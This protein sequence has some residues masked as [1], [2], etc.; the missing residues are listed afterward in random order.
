VGFDF[1]GF[2]VRQYRVGYH[3]SGRARPGFKTLIKPSADA[4]QRHLQKLAV[5]VRSHRAA[6]QEKLIDALNYQ[7]DGW[8][9][10]YRAQVSSEVFSKMDHLLFIKLWRWA[11]RR[12][13]A[14][15]RTWVAGRYWRH[16]A[17]RRWIFTTGLFTDLVRHARK[18]VEHEK[19]AGTASPF[20]GNVLYWATRLGRHPELSAGWATMLKRQGGRCAVCGLYFQT[21]DEAI[22]CDHVVPL[23][24]E[25]SRAMTNRQLVHGHCHDTKTAS[26][27]SDRVRRSKVGPGWNGPRRP[28]SGGTHDKGR[29]RA[30]AERSRAEEPCEGK[31]SSTVL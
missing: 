31:L 13:P 11:R 30:P 28:I 20:D 24:L 7:V 23:A 18:I 25:G 12:H 26:D 6:S 15:S 5:T 4:Q 9:N 17:G 22:E 16:E 29:K 10:Y 21:L 8:A 27:G 19:V 1:L 3:R 14:K 2:N